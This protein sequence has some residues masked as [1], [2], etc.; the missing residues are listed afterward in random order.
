MAEKTDIYNGVEHPP[1]TTGSISILMNG[2]ARQLPA[3]LSVEALLHDLNLPADRIAVELNKMIVRK[4][5]WQTTV[6]DHGAQVEIVEFVGG[7]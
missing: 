6:I 1:V 2:E 3:A 4:R 7:G 5:D